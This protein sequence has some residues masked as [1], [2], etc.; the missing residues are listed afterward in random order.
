MLQ[1]LTTGKRTEIDAL[2]GEVL[3]LA[4][5]YK[6]AAPYNQAVYE[7]VKFMEVKT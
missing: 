5:K 4:R 1:D 3:K 2:N 6:V 7:L